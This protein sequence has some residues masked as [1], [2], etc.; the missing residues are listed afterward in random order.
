MPV[1]RIPGVGKT[2]DL[3]PQ[4]AD[5]LL[6]LV[7]MLDRPP[8]DLTAPAQQEILTGYPDWGYDDGTWTGLAGNPRAWEDLNALELARQAEDA[9]PLPVN[10]EER[11]AHLMGR[12]ARRTYTPQG[13]AA[14]EFSGHGQGS[15][16]GMP[17]CGTADEYGYCM[18]R[19]HAPGCGSTADPFTAQALRPQMAALAQRPWMDADGRVWQD[20]EHGSNMALV[21]HLE[22][23]T[24]QR[25]GDV[26]PFETGKA[27]R[28]V[29]QVDRPV[30]IGDPDF[31][32]IAPVPVPAAAARTAAALLA[33][34]GITTY[35]SGQAQRDAQRAEHARQKARLGRPRHADFR[36][37][38]SNQVP[39]ET[40]LR[41]VGDPPWNGSLPVYTRSAA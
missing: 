20:R 24:G 10:A 16:T 23:M 5:R 19:F 29:T 40:R 11:M 7:A 38:L 31:P 15:T 17:T 28:E 36:A 41:A 37:D 30:V 12:A 3:S 35:A 39:R 1:V 8:I 6:E 14:W 26:S 25:L 33:Q 27:R 2:P 13:A 4:H 21:D 32:E 34:A 22:S 9:V 18:Q